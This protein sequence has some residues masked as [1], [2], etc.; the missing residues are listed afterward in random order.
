M[1]MFYM[2]IVK[3][4]QVFLAK[5]PH[6]AVIINNLIRRWIMLAKTTNR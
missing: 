4:G 2:L 6:A 5:G 3:F 1:F